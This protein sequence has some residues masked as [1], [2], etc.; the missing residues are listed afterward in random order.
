MTVPSVRVAQAVVQ[1]LIRYGVHDVVLAPGSR[2]A[3]LAYALAA[4]DRAGALTLHVR[5][6]ERSAAFLAVGLARGA[7]PQVNAGVELPRP[8][9]V[10]TTSGTA[11]ANLHPA[12]LEAHHAGLPVV[13]LTA[14]RPAELRG[15]G[16]NQTI[17]QSGIFGPAVR[18][19]VDLPAPDGRAEEVGDAVA[20][21]GRALA[22][23]LGTRTA[24]PGPVHLN[25]A[26]RP[27]LV[28]TEPLPDDPVPPPGLSRATVVAPVI[29][30]LPVSLD[31]APSAARTVVI[32]GDGAGPV[33]RQ[34]AEAQGWPLFA[35][36]SS[37]AVGGPQH[38]TGYPLL[39]A[40]APV[41]AAIEHAVVLGRPTL[42]R[43]VQTVL[44]APTVEV[45]VIAPGAAPWPDPAR[46]ADRVLPAVPPSW[47]VPAVADEDWSDAWR[48]ASA[49][50]AEVVAAAAAE[51]SGLG[52]AMTVAQACGPRDLVVVGSSSPVRDLEIA[53][54]TQ[55]PRIVAN[56]GVA[57]IDGMLSTIIGVAI[58][59]GR[60]GW[61]TRGLVGDLTFLHDIGGLAHGPAEPAADVQI[62]VVNDN[63]GAIFST[64]EPGGLAETTP[65][66]R[67]TFE[68]VFGTAHGADLGQLCAGY[69][70]RHRRVTS[71]AALRLVLAEPGPGVEVIEV[72]LDRGVRRAR[73]RSLAAEI[74]RACAALGFP[75]AAE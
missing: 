23:A 28:P 14:D 74:D 63:G 26:F 64:L 41:V 1:E 29:A 53:L 38:V 12:V 4:A 15:T 24:H 40:R 70:I 55:A 19:C 25:I 44:A 20:T 10:V 37:G 69:G 13:L 9:A 52:V 65:A 48:A 62:V 17:D 68:R 30:T 27:P 67:V 47:L 2:S 34:L 51:H 43:A 7:E 61:R 18:A 73:A 60:L 5:I 54:G 36:P 75:F 31:V 56:R 59:A 11:V 46:A 33:A 42:S 50:V 57:G 32:A 6:D 35:E 22:A 3:P 21:V 45:T 66:A 39:V 71:L 58:A 16:A 72:P 49:V 8:V